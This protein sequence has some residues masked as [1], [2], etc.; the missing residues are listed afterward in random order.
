MLRYYKV[1]LLVSILLLALLTGSTM[2]G[3]Q[4]SE[5]FVYWG[6]L[7]FSEDANDAFVAE[8]EEWGE[9]RGV[10]D[11]W[12]VWQGRLAVAIEGLLAGDV[13]DVVEHVSR[14]LAGSGTDA[15]VVPSC[16]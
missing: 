4:D 1:L 2:V 3:A 7:I 14:L 12:G 11:D 5:T 9:A 16:I 10:A 15:V 13:G 8:I 6:G